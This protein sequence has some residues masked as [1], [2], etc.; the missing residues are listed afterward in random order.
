MKENRR[1]PVLSGPLFALLFALCLPRAF[2]QAALGDEAVPLLPGPPVRTADVPTWSRPSD[3]NAPH[4][5]TLPEAEP[6]GVLQDQRGQVRWA[7]TETYKASLDAGGF[8]YIPFL[9][10]KAE[11]N[12]PLHLRLERCTSGDQSQALE[13]AGEVRIQGDRWVLDRGPVEVWYDLTEQGVKQSFAFDYLPERGDLTV[14]L[15]VQTDLTAQRDALGLRFECER[16]AVLYRGALVYDGAG[17]QVEIPIE[18]EAGTIRMTIPATFL[19]EARGQVVLD[20]LIG[21]FSGFPAMSGYLRSPDLAYIGT[22]SRYAYSYVREFSAIDGDIFVDYRNADT[23]AWVSRVVVDASTEDWMQPAIASNVPAGQFLV[24]AIAVNGS[25]AGEVRGRAF[26]GN[27]PALT[28]PTFLVG[29]AGPT[30]DNQDCDVGGAWQGTSQFAAVWSRLDVS[31][32]LHGTIRGRSIQPVIPISTTTPPSMG[33]EVAI[34]NAPG[35]NDYGV[36][37]SKACG[38]ASVNEWSIM[39]LRRDWSTGQVLII[40]QRLNANFT[41][42]STLDVWSYSYVTDPP[43][44]IEV[45]EPSMHPD[46][47]L[48]SEPLYLCAIQ[49]NYQGS[50][51]VYVR[52]V[53]NHQERGGTLLRRIEHVAPDHDYNSPSIANVGNRWVVGYGDEASPT[54]IRGYVSVLDWTNQEDF[55]VNERRLQ[56]TAPSGYTGDPAT[57][58]VVSRG[59]GG[60]VGNSE[61]GIAV[62]HGTGTVQQLSGAYLIANLPNSPAAQY[63]EGNPNSTGGYGFITARGDAST[64]GLKTLYAEGLPLN[65]FGYFLASH[66]GVAQGSVPGSAGVLCIAGGMIGRYNQ[67]SEIF[68][69]GSTGLGSLVIDPQALRTPTGSMAAFAGLPYT[70]QAWHREPG[71]SSNFTNAIYLAF[72]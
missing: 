7:I 30:W 32:G 23:G 67:P 33:P 48:T 61:A 17:H 19:A 14:E 46:R 50:S 31:A 65:Q 43:V 13:G 37:I 29:S 2:G 49:Y 38:G 4:L 51:S 70:F 16:G 28:S 66:G 69:T 15:A 71:G 63:C 20:P 55:A 10:S 3:P 36:T 47:Y 9:G 60:D 68:Y 40:D 64:T 72:E 57:T 42:A 27:T 56:V 54:D 8:T 5:R 34:S 45:A 52:A 26:D 24:L 62:S 35:F 59:S 11:R 53:Q 1:R 12:W 39:A 18:W 22:F 21:T 41:A 58:A 25:G 44:A 6:L